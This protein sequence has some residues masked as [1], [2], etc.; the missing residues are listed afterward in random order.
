[1]KKMLQFYKAAVIAAMAP[2][3]IATALAGS[4]APPPP[5][6]MVDLVLGKPYTI[7]P[8]VSIEYSFQSGQDGYYTPGALTDGQIASSLALAD[9]EWQG[10]ERGGARS[11]VIDMGEVNTVHQMQERFV[12]APSAGVYFP[13]SV[14]YSVSMNDTDWSVVGT[15]NSAIPLS[16]TANISQTYSVAGLNYKARYVK[17]SF[18]VDVFVFA[19][20][21]QVFG[22]SGAAAS[23]TV[24]PITPP[25]TYPNAYCAPGSPQMAGIHDMVLIPNGYYASNP[26]IQKNSFS[27]LLPYVGYQS[28]M[29]S[30][31]DFMFDAV[32]FTP[33]GG[34]PSGGNYGISKTSPANLSDWIYFL[35]NTF[36]PSYNLAALDSATAF[37]KKALNKPTYR[38]KVEIAIPY[39]NASA[40]SFGVLN[41]DSLNLSYLSDREQLLKWYVDQVISK[42]DSAGYKNLELA[43]F[44]WYSESIGYTVD[45]SEAAM[46]AYVANYIV[47]QNKVLDWIPFKDASGFAEWSNLGFD[48]AWMQPNYT[49]GSYPP[50]ELEETANAC[51][52]LGMGIEIEIHWNAL[53]DS[54][55]RDKYYQYLNYG[56]KDGYMTGATHAYY[57]NSGPG[58]FYTCAQST[59]PTLRG[60]YDATYQFI[61][62]TYSPVTAV[63]EAPAPVATRFNLSDNYPNPFNPSTG[64]K[65]TL[66]KSGVMSLKIY[67]V[68]GQ[69]V[70]IV[71]EGY[72]PAG[73]YTY[74]VNMDNF[75]SGVYF[76]RLQQGTNNIT[77]KMLLLK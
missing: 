63:K 22:D 24:P 29:G 48:G 21:F 45:D 69:L 15:V 12:N 66:S 74:N 42:W 46:I 17:M 3:M 11:V 25:V 53:T 64:M 73:V 8:L 47:G 20:E 9:P 7:T 41:G 67:N 51:K 18:P 62:G 5:S 1:M 19:D 38:E 72:K 33:Y 52:K 58:T 14:T 4:P 56:V 27:Q 34:A 54:T 37:V 59:D 16:S 44:Y 55:L 26:A 43:G 6:G 23:A 35:N 65:V 71:D 31:T 13:R 30:I 77:K 36:M 49:F 2:V 76:Y 61:K 50:Q 75:A 32:L 28:A 68:L 39:P 70:K 40:T 60:I 10:Y 57:Q